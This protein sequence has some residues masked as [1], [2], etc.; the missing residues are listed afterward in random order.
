MRHRLSS[1]VLTEFVYVMDRVYQVPKERS[2][3]ML[4]DFVALP[5]VTICHETDL[6]LLLSL[7]P[8]A[9]S[10]FG[11]AIIAATCKSHKGSTVVTF[12]VKF[13]GSLKRLGMPLFQVE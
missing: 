1:H 3:T 9:V 8:A 4:R 11:D 12:D 6:A 13:A 7:W 10:D 2:N 5:G